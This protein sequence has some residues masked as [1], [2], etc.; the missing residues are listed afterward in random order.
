MARSRASRSSARRFNAPKASPCIR[1]NPAGFGNRLEREIDERGNVQSSEDRNEF[2]E[3]TG[4]E[5]A[6]F[7]SAAPKSD[8]DPRGRPPVDK[9]LSSAKITS[10]SGDCE[11][12]FVMQSAKD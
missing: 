10:R 3:S 9:T 8:D 12:V 4:A 2:V 6:Q 7:S 5:V 11:D 1:R